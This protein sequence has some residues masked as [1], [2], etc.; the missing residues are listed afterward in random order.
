MGSKP[1]SGTLV[2]TPTASTAYMLTCTGAAGTTAATGTVTVSVTQPPEPTVTFTA[3]PTTIV[4]GGISTLS[5]SS[6]NATVCTASGAAGWTGNE[7]T[8][9]LITVTP[10]TTTTYTLTC[11]G[12]AG[13][14]PAVGTA[15]ITVTPPSNPT[16]TFAAIP[17]SVVAGS[18]STLTWS[19][20]N[21]TGGC[22]ASGATGW[23]GT[24]ATTGSLSVTPSATTTYSLS[25]A[26]ATGTTAA[27]GTAT[28]TVTSASP[29]GFAVTPRNAALTLSQTQQFTA[30]SAGTPINNATWSVDN[31]PGGNATV[32]T[33]DTTGFY[34]PPATAGTHTVTAQ[35]ADASQSATSAVAV[36]DLDGVYTFHNDVARTGANLKEYALTPASVSSASFGKQ[37]QCTTDG[38]ITAQ[39]LY[40][41]NL[42]IGGGTHNVLFV[43]TQNDT[44]YAFDADATNCTTYWVVTYVAVNAPT[45][46]SSTAAGLN[47]TG[48]GIQPRPATAD[49]AAPNYLDLIVPNGDPSGTHDAGGCNDMIR[50]GITGTPVIDPSTQIIYFVATTKEN[51]Q[52]GN[53]P[54]FY[55]RL[56]A[57]NISTGAEQNNS[58]TVITA[59]VPGN[60]TGSVNGQIN[61]SALWHNQRSGLVLYN[62]G[63]YISWGAHCDVGTYWGWTMRFNTVTNDAT[64]LTRTSAFVVAPNGNKGGIWMSAGAAAVDSSGSLFLTTGNGTFDTN[65]SPSVPATAANTYDFS[66]SFLNFST[67]TSDLIVQDFYTPTNAVN[68]SNADLDISASGVT[69]LNDGRGPVGHPNLLTG[70]DKQGHLWLIDRAVGSMSEYTP[71]PGVDGTVQYLQLPTTALCG[72]PYNCLYGAPAYYHNAGTNTDTVYYGP[73]N[74]PV[75]ALT[76][77]GGLYSV[78]PNSQ[79]IANPSSYSTETYRYPGVTPAVTASPA[80][81][82]L[83]WALDNSQYGAQGNNGASV[84]GT[85][86]LRAYDATTLATL[87]DSSASTANTN[88]KA[89]KFTRPVIANGRVYVGGDGATSCGQHCTNSTPP[90]QLTVY[91]LSP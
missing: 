28:V 61:F 62:S 51:Y 67:T 14:T 73:V 33:I 76:L 68:W 42:S 44:V 50:F 41:A 82:G 5:W 54:D 27:T 72:A 63:I 80:G 19:T 85:S 59:S 86:I 65:P 1:T 81:G 53:T 24:Q 13:T 40:V 26:G 64:S 15:T 48:L 39:P 45:N 10:A 6:T 84:A 71:S 43:V 56:H 52:G 55:Q 74:N 16:V 38:E 21:A 22:T 89:I 31:I 11:T 12:A 17:T 75:M 60:G 66:M 29:S 83:V 78:Q 25:C 57:L 88:G 77:A 91:G 37:F 46:A 90:G 34:T 79:N 23:T 2:V 87:F 30:T 3:N 58:P 47:L 36:T 35:S 4:S 7:P 32:G 9:F 8:P 18:S 70:S 69:V 49:A 20:T